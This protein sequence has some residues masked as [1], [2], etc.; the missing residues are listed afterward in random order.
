MKG[1]CPK[2]GLPFLHICYAPIS[3][4]PPPPFPH[5]FFLSWGNHPASHFFCEEGIP[6][7][8][9][10]VPLWQDTWIDKTTCP[11]MQR[12]S[13]RIIRKVLFLLRWGQS[14][15]RGGNPNKPTRAKTAP[16]CEKRACI[17]WKEK[18]G[19]PRCGLFVWLFLSTA[20]FFWTALPVFCYRIVLQEPIISAKIP[21]VGVPV[22]PANQSDCG[23]QWKKLN[24]TNHSSTTLE[25]GT[26]AFLEQH[27]LTYEPSPCC[28]RVACAQIS[29]QVAFHS[30]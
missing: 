3:H 15:W 18:A 17:H 14:G 16:A 11:R 22:W 6:S 26:E 20:V 1:K 10:C 9:G 29:Y 4:F 24:Y 7:V 25:M 28:S 19:E 30:K 21:Q 8:V 13:F 27:R 5:S 2:F 12:A 23:L